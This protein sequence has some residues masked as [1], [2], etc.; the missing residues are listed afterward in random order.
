M[1][2]QNTQIEIGK[3]E[4]PTME[5]IEFLATISIASHIVLG[6]AILVLLVSMVTVAIKT[7]LPGRFLTLFSVL[8]LITFLIYQIYMGGNL[9]SVFGPIGNLYAAIAYSLAG[10]LFAIGFSR[11]CWYFKGVDKSA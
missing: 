8:L 3:V 5:E 9:E 10:V 2:V 6:V 11:M 1:K 4:S 7:Q